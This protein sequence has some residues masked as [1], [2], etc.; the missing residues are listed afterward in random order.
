MEKLRIR[1]TKL[2]LYIALTTQGCSIYQ[3]NQLFVVLSL[4]KGG[5]PN[6]CV[7]ETVREKR[8]DNK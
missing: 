7:G 1:P 8:E 6:A 2:S 4:F 3:V 5:S